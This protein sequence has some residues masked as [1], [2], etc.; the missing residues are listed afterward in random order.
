MAGRSPAELMPAVINLSTIY[1]PGFPQ[2]TSPP[3][4]R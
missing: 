2:G 4:S 1:T 3:T